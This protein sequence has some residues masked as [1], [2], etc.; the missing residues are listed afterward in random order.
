MR[1]S[2]CAHRCLAGAV[3]GVRT[4]AW[5]VSGPSCILF[6]ICGS[7]RP[8]GRAG[9]SREE[10]SLML[11]GRGSKERGRHWPRG[12]SKQGPT[13]RTEGLTVSGPSTGSL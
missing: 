5:R 10:V 7:S 1:A 8:V 6:P 4:L 9:L 11:T 3:L 12:E 13:R 2:P